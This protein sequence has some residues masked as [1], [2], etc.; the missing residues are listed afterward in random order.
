MMEAHTL[1]FRKAFERLLMKCLLFGTCDMCINMH[2]L[3]KMFWN[4]HPSGRVELLGRARG[5]E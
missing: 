1:R 2:G 3:D 4:C 5:I